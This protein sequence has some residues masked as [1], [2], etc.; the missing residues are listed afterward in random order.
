MVWRECGG[1]IGLLIC[2]QG[3]GVHAN[4]SPRPLLTIQCLTAPLPQCALLLT[5][6]PAPIACKGTKTLPRF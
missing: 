1:R 5:P 6:L 2:Q 3:R 4:M